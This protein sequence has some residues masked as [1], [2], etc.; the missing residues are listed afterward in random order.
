MTTQLN[1]L[2]MA[3]QSRISDNGEMPVYCRLTYHQR[4]KR[5]M[6]GCKV[7]LEM[8]NQ[9]KQRANGKSSQAQIINQH[10]T[11]IRQ[12]VH[13]AEAELL[14]RA[15][16]FEVED[17]VHLVQGST[18]AACHTLMQLYQHRLKQIH[19]VTL[20][21]HYID[22]MNSPM[23]A[24]EGMRFTNFYAAQP[25]CTAF[26]AAILTG[27]ILIGLEFLARFSQIPR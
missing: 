23:I 7:P 4:Q 1:I 19:G 22:A 16:A 6:I 10:V 9:S 26:R 15:E 5:F 11:S 13:N 17:I 8:W 27:A 3:L 21:I 2:F 20:Y 18:K 25:I 12:K 24:A 14:K